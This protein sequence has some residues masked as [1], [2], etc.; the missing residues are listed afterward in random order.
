[1][2]QTL[3]QK[4]IVMSSKD[5]TETLSIK[6]IATGVYFLRIDDGDAAQTVKVVIER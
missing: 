4:Q 1:M 3:I 6:D 5:Y 2:G